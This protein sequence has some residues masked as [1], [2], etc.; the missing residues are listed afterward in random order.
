MKWKLF[1][2]FDENEDREYFMRTKSELLENEISSESASDPRLEISG[3]RNYCF[4]Q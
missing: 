3:V 4:P 1:G 2:S